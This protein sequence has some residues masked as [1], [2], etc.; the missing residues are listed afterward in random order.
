MYEAATKL[1]KTFANLESMADKPLLIGSR[2]NRW[3]SQL[4]KQ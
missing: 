3:N 1:Q 2:N 4:Q